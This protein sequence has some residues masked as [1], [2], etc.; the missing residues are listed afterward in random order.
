MENPIGNFFDSHFNSPYEKHFGNPPMI[1]LRYFAQLRETLNCSQETLQWQD[2]IN[3]VAA[4]KTQLSQ[5]ASHNNSYNDQWQKAFD[6]NI[7][8]AVNQEIT[9]DN[10]PVQDNDEVAFFPPVTGG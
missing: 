9:Q 7:L 1:T 8:C 4:L 10:H 3:T 2:N 6:G 5:R